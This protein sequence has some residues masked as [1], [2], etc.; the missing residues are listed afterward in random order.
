LKLYHCYNESIE[1]INFCV[2]YNLFY[3]NN[4]KE[5]TYYKKKYISWKKR[6]QSN[7]Q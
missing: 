1:S 5:S 6:A 4:K 7:Y 2:N 3:S